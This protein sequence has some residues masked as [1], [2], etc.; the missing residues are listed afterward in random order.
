VQRAQH[1][2]TAE[3]YALAAVPTHTEQPAAAL[4]CFSRQSRWFGYDARMAQRVAITV[5]LGAG[6]PIEVVRQLIDDLDTACQFGG[7]LEYL[8]VQGQAEFAVLRELNADPAS[9]E[10]SHPQRIWSGVPSEGLKPILARAIAQYMA[11]TNAGQDT[12]TTVESIRYSNPIEFILGAA[13]VTTVVVLRTIRDWP[14][15]RRLNKAVADE[16]ANIVLARKQLR[17]EIVRRAVE[18]NIF[19]SVGQIDELLTLDVT[20]A[21]TALGDSNISMHELGTQEH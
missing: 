13:L 20:K 16:A 11:N 6:A 19:I 15:R 1:K 8:S 10:G 18:E 12:I 5:N 2:S 7:E 4:A 9:D 21:L 17:D 3:R 14:D